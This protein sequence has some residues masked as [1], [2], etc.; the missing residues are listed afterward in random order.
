MCCMFSGRERSCSGLAGVFELIIDIIE[1]AAWRFAWR[2]EDEER[3]PTADWRSRRRCNSNIMVE[4]KGRSHLFGGSPYIIAGV[5]EK[6]LL[7]GR[8]SHQSHPPAHPGKVRT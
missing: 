2:R 6:P 7:L 5:E 1:G 8:L 3:K 4:L